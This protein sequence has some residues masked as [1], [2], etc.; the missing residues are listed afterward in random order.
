MN[1]S[2]ICHV[3]FTFLIYLDAN[4]HLDYYKTNTKNIK[5]VKMTQFFIFGSNVGGGTP[6]LPAK[7]RSPES[8]DSGDLK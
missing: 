8:L 1:C 5:N 3:V 4:L 6:P 2:G 7:K